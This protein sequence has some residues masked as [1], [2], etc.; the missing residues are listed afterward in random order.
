MRLQKFT[1]S[2]TWLLSICCLT[3][4]LYIGPVTANVQTIT[5]GKSLMF[6]CQQALAILNQDADTTSDTDQNSAFVCMAY[7]SGMM[8]TAQHANEQAKLRYSLLTNGRANR[9][10]FGLYCFDWL[11]SYQKIAHIVLEFGRSNPAYLQQPAHKLAIRALQTA[12]P[13]R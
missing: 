13:C 5:H 3:S 11:L 1:D 12:F 2:P 10:D 7:L 8:T 6:S 9:H 4:I